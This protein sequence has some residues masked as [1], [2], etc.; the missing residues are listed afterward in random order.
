LVD[1]IS[2]KIWDA[3]EKSKHL[4]GL[5]DI[6][7]IIGNE[8]YSLFADENVIKNNRSEITNQIKEY[9]YYQDDVLIKKRDNS[10]FWGHLLISPFKAV[11]NNYYLIQI[12][13]IDNKKKFD[14]RLI[15]NNEKYQ[16]IMDNLEEFIYLVSYDNGKEQF[17]Y[18]SPYI[19]KMFGITKEEY[20][21][22]KL[23]KK[24]NSVYHPDDLIKNKEIKEKL[25]RTKQKVSVKYRI[26]PIGKDNYIT[27]FE[28][29]IPK[30]NEKGEI[31]QV[32]GI[33]REVKE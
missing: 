28:T 20:L 21:S 6:N 10:T 1:F 32:L 23:R 7:E 25:F 12:K 16:F 30:L 29:A 26:K 14:D 19:G 22:D 13:N 8:Y 18:I 3:N 5:L 33:I 15:S 24:V 2:K 31:S 27:I 4:F 11:K 17:E 9:G